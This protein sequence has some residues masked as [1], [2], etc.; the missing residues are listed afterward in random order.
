MFKNDDIILF[1]C[2]DENLDDVLYCKKI[3]CHFN[4]EFIFEKIAF[5]GILFSQ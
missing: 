1:K 3:L 2:I 5:H 4:F